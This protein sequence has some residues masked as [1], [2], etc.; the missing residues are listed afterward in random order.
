MKS[1]I[2]VLIPAGG[3]GTR[4]GG[5]TKKQ[6]LI[7]QGQTILM[8]SLK[9]F[10]AIPEVRQVIVA[11]PADEIKV[12]QESNPTDRVICVVG[13][14]N[15]AESVWRAFQALPKCDVNDIILIHDAVRPLVSKE[16]IQRVVDGVKAKGT[17]LPVVPVTDTIKEV[18]NNFVLRTCDRSQLRAAQTPQGVRYG[19]LQDAYRKAGD[20]LTLATDEA[21]LLEQAG[22]KVFTVAGEVQNIKVTTPMDLKV[23]EAILGTPPTPSC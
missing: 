1:N 2:Y 20:D 13:G 8:R 6:F 15:R 9:T 16:L 4:F 22:H 14:A 17:A 19:I 3:S 10:L 5:G 18:Q 11:L 12:P 23:A 21:M 7:L